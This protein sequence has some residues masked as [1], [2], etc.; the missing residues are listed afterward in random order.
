[1]ITQDELKRI[2]KYNPYT[3]VF[4]SKVDSKNKRSGDILGR[5][6]RGY[7]VIYIKNYNYRAHRLAWLYVHGAFPVNDIDHINGNRDDNRIS[8]LRSVTNQE[9]HKNKTLLSNNKHGVTGVGWCKK[10]LIWRVSITV[11]LKHVHI[12]YYSSLLDAACARKAK[13]RLYGFHV[14]HGKGK[15]YIYK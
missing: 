11:D 10:R 2:L 7:T 9:N 1:M 15:K 5:N 8:N 14:N 3:G 13:E 4:T 6:S 12:G